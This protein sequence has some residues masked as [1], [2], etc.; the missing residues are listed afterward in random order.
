MVQCGGP[1]RGFWLKVRG[2]ACPAVR[3][4]QQGTE[5]SVQL[6]PGPVGVKTQKWATRHVGREGCR[7][8]RRLRANGIQEIRPLKGL[9]SHHAGVQGRDPALGRGTGKRMETPQ[10]TWEA[11][12]IRNGQ[13]SCKNWDAGVPDVAQW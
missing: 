8:I 9:L 12:R 5:P 11:G 2:E 13:S 4:Q 3:S 1:G 6:S 10:R 7:A